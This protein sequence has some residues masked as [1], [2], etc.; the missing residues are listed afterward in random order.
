MVRRLKQKKF[1]FLQILLFLIAFFLFWQRGEGFLD[2]DFGW[3]YKM[4]ELILKSGVPKTD[5]FSYT[6]PSFPFVGHEWL[7]DIITYKLY[8]L[9]G[10]RLLAILYSLLATLS[11]SISSGFFKK[12]NHLKIPKFSF[13]I[14]AVGAILPF[15]G[16][17]P[18]VL[19]WLFLALWLKIILSDAVLGKFWFFL[20][21]FIL[22]WANLHASFS[23]GILCLGTVFGINFLKTKKLVWKEVL[24]FF[25]CLVATFINPYGP[26]LWEEVWRSVS[27]SAL[28]WRIAEWNP[29]L[30]APIL[31]YLFLL[32]FAFL[33]YCFY[34]ELSWG[35]IALYLFFLI[36]SLLGLRYIPLF[37]VVSFPIYLEALGYLY[38]KVCRIEYGK[39]RW[40]KMEIFLVLSCFLVTG[41]QAF[42]AIKEISSFSER[43]FYPSAAI[44]YLKQNLPRG[45]LLSQYNWGGYLIWKLPE[46]K[47][48]IDG[49]M[50]SWRWKANLPNESKC[51]MEDYLKMQESEDEFKKQLVKYNISTVLWLN[52]K[53]ESGIKSV[54]ENLFLKMFKKKENFSLVDFLKKE[55][56]RVVYQDSVA[57][58]YTSRIG[59]T[60]EFVIK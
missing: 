23:V 14:L 54:I 53:K 12:D 21:V 48:F 55:E 52:E 11:L 4:G 51:A 40:Q 38:E 43:V 22:A 8:G 46:K 30:F 28:R 25:L 34:R 16:V 33:I 47:V 39:Q 26:R 1:F 59:S 24:C 60:P 50:P 5:P 41:A 2:P 7:V 9:A 42:F 36:Q 35:K 10:N 37:V 31:P 32:S 17:R 57:V 6:M 58:I 3:H 15:S 45:N 49:R 56:W 18:Q 27:D 19:S 44:A 20:P 13:F 29:S